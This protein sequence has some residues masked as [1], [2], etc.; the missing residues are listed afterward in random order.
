MKFNFLIGKI[1]RNNT[2]GKVVMGGVT[3]VVLSV[4]PASAKTTAQQKINSVSPASTASTKTTAQQ[5]IYKVTCTT[6]ASCEQLSLSIQAQI[7]ELEK[8]DNLSKDEKKL[9][10]NLR[11]QLIAT[12]DS[13]IAVKD[14]I[15]AVEKQETAQGE[16]LIATKDVVLKKEKQETLTEKQETAEFKKTNIKITQLRG[17][18]L[19]K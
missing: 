12:K 19:D 5:K 16:E 13:T 2:M 4:S 8:K 11:K 14:K 6:K 3:A 17:V 7:D 1:M 18:L 9:R 15:I 10:Y